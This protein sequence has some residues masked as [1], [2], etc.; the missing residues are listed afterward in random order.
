MGRSSRS[1][2]RKSDQ[3]RGI[4]DKGAAQIGGKTLCVEESLQGWV[5]KGNSEFQAGTKTTS[6]ENGIFTRKVEK[7]GKSKGSSFDTVLQ[8]AG[9]KR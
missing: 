6:G 8:K 9:I 3:F 1:T 7:N 2:D 5:K 4:R